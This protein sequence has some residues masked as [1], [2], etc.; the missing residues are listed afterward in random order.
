MDGLGR[1]PWS[2]VMSEK[3]MFWWAIFKVDQKFG[4]EYL[5]GGELCMQ[6]ILSSLSL[7]VR[8]SS[9]DNLAKSGSQSG[10]R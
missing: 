10:S 1:E 3:V 9:P 7:F 2:R 4:D 8:F 6:G 5:L